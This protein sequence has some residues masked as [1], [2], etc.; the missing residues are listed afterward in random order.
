MQDRELVGDTAADPRHN[1]IFAYSTVA[2]GSS[3][4]PWSRCPKEQH[5]HAATVSAL[6][7]VFLLVA[8]LIRS[9]WSHYH[10]SASC[11]GEARR[12]V[13]I[14]I[15]IGFSRAVLLPTPWI[16]Q[17]VTHLLPPSPQPPFHQ[18]PPLL[19][20]SFLPQWCA[21]CSPLIAAHNAPWNADRRRHA[22]TQARTHTA[23]LHASV[24]QRQKWMWWKDHM[25]TWDQLLAPSYYLYK[26]AVFSELL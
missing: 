10:I 12:L 5:S 3:H 23:V 2:A 6:G 11:E 8:V 18:F 14:Q 9:H 21:S 24:H 20:F 13:Q 22:H 1:L 15:W 26:S 16:F 17:H 7:A 19:G 4:A 25:S